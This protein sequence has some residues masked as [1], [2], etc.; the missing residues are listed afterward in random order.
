[1]ET[2]TLKRTPLYGCH[3]QAG[4][5]FVG[6]GGWEMPVQYSGVIEEHRTVRSA[7][8]LFD[9]SHMGE[10][11]V[12]GPKAFEFLQD[13]SANDL[14]KTKPGR[15][16][17]S[18]LL[19]EQGGVVDDI[20]IYQLA[21]EYYLV[22]VNASNTDKDYEWLTKH[23][24]AGAKIV[25]RS[26]EYAQLA[27]QGPHAAGLLEALL[28]T[29]ESAFSQANFANFAV[30]VE[31][32]GA[33]ELIIARTGY[34]GEDGFEIF[35]SADAAALLWDA[36]LEIG[37]HF[38][39]KP[40]GLAAR[41]TLRLEAALPLYGHELRDD[42]P[43]L[44][45]TMG[46]AVKADKPEFVG[47]DAVL[48]QKES[49]CSQKLVGFEVVERGIARDGMKIFAGERE[50]GWVASGTFG[51]TVERAVGTAYVASEF[52]VLDTEISA[53]IRGKLTKIKVVKMPFYKRLREG[54]KL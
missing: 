24:R 53:D 22:C 20:I 51:P 54:G 28:E 43:V 4:A 29:E 27:V 25:N 34:T 26:S 23:N 14:S 50:I 1:M 47:R 9:V 18:L 38:G 42:I 16:Q 5:K 21:A 7:V 2:T 44:A 35:F 19:N 15:A 31:N 52:A 13:V 37:V 41:D 6:F 39:I 32:F 30:R 45:G 33:V 46:W 3:Q 11:F 10:I 36:F 48:V 49:G 17:Y 40:I 8:G 12:S